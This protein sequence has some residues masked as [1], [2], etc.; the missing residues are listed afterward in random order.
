V[1]QPRTPPPSRQAPRGSGILILLLLLAVASLTYVGFNLLIGR[2]KQLN[3]ELPAGPAT[4]SA[5][6]L[7]ARAGAQA[8]S[9][10]EPPEGSGPPVVVDVKPRPPFAPKTFA[11]L[12]AIAAGDRGQVAFKT[13]RSD[14]VGFPGCPQPKVYVLVTP[15]TPAVKQLGAALLAFFFDQHLA[16]DCGA[17]L[18][19]YQSES[20]AG[21]PGTRGEVTL[22]VQGNPQ[23]PAEGHARPHTIAVSLPDRSSFSLTYTPA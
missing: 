15:Q 1:R 17:S 3:T 2:N 11:D 18:R 7:T 4:S 13:L 22:D 16:N 10:T 21:G 9:Q 8:G 23:G 19:G 6:S 12:E 14:T 20:E 5:T